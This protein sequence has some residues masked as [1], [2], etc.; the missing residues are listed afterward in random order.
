MMIENGAQ[1]CF[2]KDKKG[3]LPAHV[4]CS[5][6]CS[7]EK[8]RMLLSINPGSLYDT[9]AQ[10]QTLLDLATQTATKSHPNYA[11]IDELNRH[12]SNC[13]VGVHSNDDEHLS[14]ALPPVARENHD[15]KEFRPVLPDPPHQQHHP[16]MPD[17]G[18]VVA[19]VNARATAAGR[20]SSEEDDLSW[21]NRSRLDSN[22]SSARSW[23]THE[24]FMGRQQREETPK[25]AKQRASRKRKA[26]PDP[27][28]D[29]LLHFS[30]N[31]KGGSSSRRDR[32]NL[33]FLEHHHQSL[34]TRIAEV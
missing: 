13:G 31:S 34:P 25:P 24:S 26:N 29:L 5:R 15:Y 10:G 23:N 32:R 19:A 3:Y 8:L 30:R 22:D 27:A 1:A 12:L 14:V 11:L 7:P 9:T 33:D 16:A 20:V 28:A 18:V 4:A 17:L 21:N 6:H 2:M